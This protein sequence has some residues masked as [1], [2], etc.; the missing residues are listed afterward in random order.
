MT[1]HIMEQIETAVRSIQQS[2]GV[3]ERQLAWMRGT[4]ADLNPETRREIA[5][6]ANAIQTAAEKIALAVVSDDPIGF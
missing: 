5:D 4:G 2:A 3:I 1:R 6:E